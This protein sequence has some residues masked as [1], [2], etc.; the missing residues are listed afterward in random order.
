MFISNRGLGQTWPIRR[1][2]HKGC[3]YRGRGAAPPPRLSETDP[4]RKEDRVSRYDR[5]RDPCDYS[6]QARPHRLVCELRRRRA[7]RRGARIG[8]FIGYRIAPLWPTDGAFFDFRVAF[9][10]SMKSA[11]V[12]LHLTMQFN[13]C[14]GSIG[15]LSSW[16]LP[17]RTQGAALKGVLAP[18]PVFASEDLKPLCDGGPQ[19]V[20]SDFSA[21]D[22][23]ASPF[24]PATPRGC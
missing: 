6:P 9:V 4:V 2:V 21:L 1:I 13:V 16:A 5:C 17:R 15:I 12:A 3:S 10:P 7:I 11:V 18:P 14:S 19:K 8:R 23:F 22:R 20:A 24:S